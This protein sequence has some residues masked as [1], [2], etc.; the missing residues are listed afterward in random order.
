MVV[1]SGHNEIGFKSVEKVHF[2]AVGSL[3]G[4]EQGHLKDLIG[5]S[6]HADLVRQQQAEANKGGGISI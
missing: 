3:N 2:G 1:N 5:G 4:A 6:V